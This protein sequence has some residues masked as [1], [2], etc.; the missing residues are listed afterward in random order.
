MKTED[1]RGE[2]TGQTLSLKLLKQV[3]VAS[4]TTREVENLEVKTDPKTGK[5]STTL[6]VED[7][8]GGRYIVRAA[9]TDGF[10]N[11]V[12]NDLT[13]TISGAK[14]KT[15]LRILTD[16][17]EFK[18]D[19]EAAAHLHNRGEASIALLTWEAERILSYKVVSLQEGDSPLCWTV[20]GP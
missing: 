10:G 7:A 20:D 11:P 15:K 9:G 8:D 12:V 13:L 5:S 16:R 2:P 1:A 19:E 18:V 3:E 17:Q 6:K 4:R 14:D